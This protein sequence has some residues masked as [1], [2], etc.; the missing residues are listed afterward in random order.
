MQPII[1]A[2]IHF[3]QYTLKEQQGIMKEMEHYQIHSLISVSTNLSSA[4]ENLALYQK[5]ERIKLAF[6]YHPEQPLPTD[7]ELADLIQ[8]M[9]KNHQAMVAIGE[10]GLPYYTNVKSL[11]GYLALLEEFFKL[12]V[13]WN[14]PELYFKSAFLHYSIN[15]S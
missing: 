3:D 1:D 9:D 10:V 14:K 15:A 12:A 7:E 5:D 4:V 11:E 2:H 13:K 8:F 6:G